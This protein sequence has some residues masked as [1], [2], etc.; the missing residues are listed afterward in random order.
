[1]TPLFHC[2][3]KRSFFILEVL[4]CSFYLYSCSTTSKPI[5][6]LNDFL[7][8]TTVSVLKSD[9]RFDVINKND[10]IQITISSLNSELDEKFN[11][12]GILSTQ[13]GARSIYK[14]DNEGN[15]KVH[16]LGLIS[17]EGLTPKQLS[18]KLEKDL[19]LFYKGLIVN[20]NFIN[21]RIVVL[22]QV[23]SPKVISVSED[24]MSIFEL[25]ANC[26]DLKPD[27]DIKNI[28]ILRDSGDKKQIGVVNLASKNLF[29][30]KWYQ[31]FANDVVLVRKDDE[32]LFKTDKRKVIQSNVSL[33]VSILS[34]CVIILNII[35]R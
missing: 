26:G 15:I 18:A 27:A 6:Y 2:F 8:D 13:S 29:D 32:S 4:F 19:G 34:L 14:V 1:M 33:V 5:A 10:E 12:S 28:I 16:H 3:T 23:N 21:K 25:L 9:N 11:N 17:I 20:V 24:G 22:G 31:L 30:S 35:I 7:S